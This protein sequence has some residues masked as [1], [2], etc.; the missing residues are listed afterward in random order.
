M[1]IPRE[2]QPDDEL[3]RRF[4]RFCKFDA[5]AGKTVAVGRK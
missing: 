4:D 2:L 5:I 3:R 1:A